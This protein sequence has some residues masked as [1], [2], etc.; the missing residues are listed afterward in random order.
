MMHLVSEDP[1]LQTEVAEIKYF[2]PIAGYDS[3]R[4]RGRPDD[5]P[6]VEIQSILRAPGG[7]YKAGKSYRPDPTKARRAVKVDD[8]K[9]VSV[10]LHNS[11][12][13]DCLEDVF[14]L[15][16]SLSTDPCAFLIRGFLEDCVGRPARHRA[17]GIVGDIVYRRSVTIYGDQ[18]Y[19]RDEAHQL[20][21]LD[22]DGVP[23]PDDM[24]VVADPEAGIKWAVDHLLPPEFAEASFVYQLSS[25]AGL[26]KRDNELNVHL[27]FFTNREY[28]DVELRVWARWWNAKQQR[29]IIDP[30]LFT[31]VQPHYT[32]EP[33]LLD[34]LID[35]LAGRRLGLIRRRRRTVKLHMPTTE[36]AIA[37]LGSRQARAVKQYSRARKP[38]ATRKPKNDRTKDETSIDLEPEIIRESND[39]PFLGGPYF[40]A[41]RLGPGWRGFL[42]AIGFEGHIRTQ[43]RAA[44]G[45][46]FHEQGSR[47]D[48]E[49][50]KAEITRAIEESPFLDGADPWSRPRKDARG[51]LNGPGNSNVDEMIVDIAALQAAREHFA[52]EPCEPAWELPT[53]TAAEAFSQIEAAINDVVLEA[54]QSKERHRKGDIAA[55]LQKPPSIAVNCST[56]TGK[57]EA[58]VS[59]IAAFLALDQ[60][61]RVVIAVPT[62]KLGQGLADRINSA[63]GSDVA[64]EWYGTDHPDPLEPGEKMCRLAQAAKELFP[65]GGKLQLLCSRRGEHMEYCPHH[66]AVAGVHGCGYQRQQSS[67]MRNKT[68]IWVIPASMLATAPPVALKRAKHG[69]EGDFD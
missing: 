44:I 53:L 68:R 49:L 67:E 6:G 47:G 11:V 62:H 65:L 22:L 40:D 13:I 24:S 36:E 56:G 46:Y 23:L 63:C 52:C 58:M 9:I 48:R 28:W 26:T 45:S 43:I 51:Y 42:M 10:F 35:P 3:S 50:L 57:T 8:Y 55:L 33:E 66:P 5:F 20:Q 2:E 59:R 21:M 37:E 41:V 18:G 69:L 7:R 39:D 30:A 61:V 29:K 4:A 60:T 27:W 38:E 1:A 32:N 19:F 14:D 64:T 54:L 15:L 12:V 16:K 31:S 34:G 25:S 17:T